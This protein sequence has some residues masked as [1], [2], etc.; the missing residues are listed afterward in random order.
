MT[1]DVQAKLVVEGGIKILYKG[2]W[3]T[4]IPFDQDEIS[5]GV[6]DP[7]NDIYPD[8][9]LRQYRLDGGDP[10]ISRKHARFTKEND[11]YTVEDI[12][13][14]NS[15]SIN[16]KTGVLNESKKTLQNGDRIFISESIGFRFELCS[17]TVSTSG[18]SSIVDAQKVDSK[19]ELESLDENEAQEQGEEKTDD[20]TSDPKTPE[21]SQ[22]E[23]N[24]EENQEQKKE[25]F[26]LEVEGEE[27][28]FFKPRNTFTYVIDL[29]PDEWQEEDG[30]KSIS[31]GRRSTEDNIYPD[32]DLWK[33]YFNDGD[34]YIG[35]KHARIFED[36]G[37][38]YFQDLS[39]KG[40]TWI[41][42]KDD[43]HRLLKTA[44]DEAKKELN[45]DDKILISDSVVFTVRKH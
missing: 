39:G 10:Y 8:I 25:G 22:T 20:A 11:E 30:H 5:I 9:N 13:G 37:K 38:L 26:Y 1:Q 31:I 43:E 35:R 24:Q 40:S 6:M 12:C 14:N 45:V 15:T 19:E 29:T 41:N 4:E 44:T 16:S 42:E 33:F 17:D 34:E 7:E 3:V 36:E 23:E 27:P 2:V 32:I 18:E 28:L 21:E